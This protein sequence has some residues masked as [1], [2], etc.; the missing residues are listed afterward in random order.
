[1]TGVA[2]GDWEWG[3]S[4]CVRGRGGV[5]VQW[6]TRLIKGPREVR[7]EGGTGGTRHGVL[8]LK[9]RRSRS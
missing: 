1:M 4:E 3:L 7:V 5:Y 2:T 6:S 9:T 8:R